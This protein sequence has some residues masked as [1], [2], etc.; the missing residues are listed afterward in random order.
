MFKTIKKTFIKILLIDKLPYLLSLLFLGVG[1]SMSYLI[2]EVKGW[3]LLEY[4]ISQAVKAEEDTI[5]GFYYKIT[6]SNITSNYII[7]EVS[8]LVDYNNTKGRKIISA[9]P[10]FKSPSHFPKHDYRKDDFAYELTVNN[11]QPNWEIDIILFVTGLNVP[12]LSFF[13]DQS[14]NL[15]KRSLK[16]YIFKKQI[17]FIIILTLI[18]ILLIVSYLFVYVN[19]NDLK[20][21]K[22]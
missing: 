5:N 16:T 19:L 7:K 1:V 22:K 8:F 3:P 10:L 11:F 15:V 2:K 18:W 17:N 6:I 21:E 20:N 14:I 13:S 12:K 4:N 9:T